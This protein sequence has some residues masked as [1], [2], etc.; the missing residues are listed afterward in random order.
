MPLFLLAASILLLGWGARRKG[1]PIK[2]YLLP[3]TIILTGAVLI[4]KG[5][6]AIGGLLALGGLGWG[7]VKAKAFRRAIRRDTD[8]DVLSWRLAEARALLGLEDGADRAAVISAH[9]RL[10][11]RNHPDVGGT[12]A[13]AR[14]L[15]AARD[16][17]LKH[18]RS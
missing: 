18:G 9:R 11:A 5:S 3:G 7:K 13:L 12:D 8:H 4:A 15:N 6:V 16:L 17:L 10:I 14:N 1:W 2:P